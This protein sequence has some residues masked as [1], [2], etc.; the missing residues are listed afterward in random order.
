MQ[1]YFYYFFIIINKTVM[2]VTKLKVIWYTHFKTFLCHTRLHLRWKKLVY[3]NFFLSFS[4]KPFEF[5]SKFS[6]YIW[7]EFMVISVVRTFFLSIGVCSVL[8]WSWLSEDLLKQRI[9]LYSRR[10]VRFRAPYIMGFR[11]ELESPKS[12]YMT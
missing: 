6:F 7:V 1:I 4:F 2:F 3:S 5:R 12:L 8:L 9:F 10:N 11:E